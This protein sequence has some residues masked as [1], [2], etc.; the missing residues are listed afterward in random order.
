LPFTNPLML[1]GASL[2]AIPIII[3]LLHRRRF[4]R[5]AWAAMDWLLES[6]KRSRRRLRIEELL[7]LLVR[8][9]ILTLMGL[10]LARPVRKAAMGALAGRAR[11]YRVIA[12]DRSMSTKR[13]SGVKNSF[14]VAQE[15][16]RFLLNERAGLSQGDEVAIVAF[17]SNTEVLIKSTSDLTAASEEIASI[18]PTDGGSNAARAVGQALDLI[19][20]GVSK[21]PRK[22]IFVVS[23]MTAES[24]RG[25]TGLKDR[26]VADRMKA[27]GGEVRLFVVGV[28]RSGGENISAHDLKPETKFV[29]S[30]VPVRITASISSHGASAAKTVT[31][32]LFVDDTPHGRESITVQPGESEAVSFPLVFTEPGLRVLRLAID[33]DELKPD[34]SCFAVID[35][36]PDLGVSCVDGDPRP[37][38]LMSETAF[39][40]RALNPGGAKHPSERSPIRP[41]VVPASA[42]AEAR[43]EKADVIV[44]ANVG[45]IPRKK[46]SVLERYVAGGGGLIV[47]PGDRV[48]PELYNE[49]LFRKGKGPLPVELEAIEDV[50]LMGLRARGRVFDHPVMRVFKGIKRSGLSSARVT[51]RLRWKMPEGAAGEN[52]PTVV[53]EFS[54]G[55]PALIERKFGAGRVLLC[56]LTADKAWSDLPEKPAYLPLIHE[57]IYHAA[58]STLASNNLTVGER[59]S[60]PVRAEDYS[61][62]FNVI[63]P[64][65]RVESIT[66]EA[67]GERFEIRFDGTSNAGVYRMES[68]TGTGK[69]VFAV[70]PGPAESNLDVLAQ[71]E[72][73]EL[74]PEVPLKIVSSKR[75]ISDG[76]AM[77]VSGTEFWRP[78]VVAVL[79]LLVLESLMAWRFGARRALPGGGG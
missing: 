50:T 66:P 7:L 62:E 52:A 79:V 70:N 47:F 39:L 61:A 32:G 51:R 1:I 11:A 13:S 76:V 57:L 33:P 42:F 28:G 22:E 77:S 12:I 8:A 2:G 56:A 24:W 20:A 5:R 71:R 15:L 58:R 10:A 16:A 45:L 44:L 23:D 65:D 30:G 73:K 29:A 67:E 69:H 9:L 74:F 25:T 55:Q 41:E 54:D 26:K 72:L 17:D 68:A 35:V 21:N 60:A 34:D 53:L 75:E 4:V 38:P 40:V 59:Y 36:R 14:E 48:D 46:A 31:A 6:H 49:A 3:H 64:G 37:E 18:E 63:M 27:A 78:I 43:F 19:E